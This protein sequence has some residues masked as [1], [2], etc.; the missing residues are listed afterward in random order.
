VIYNVICSKTLIWNKRDVVCGHKQKVVKGQL[1]RGVET[2][3]QGRAKR[4]VASIWEVLEH[5][6][7]SIPFQADNRCRLVTKVGGDS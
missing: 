7:C 4:R 5:D 6:C 3:Y 1:R 2:K